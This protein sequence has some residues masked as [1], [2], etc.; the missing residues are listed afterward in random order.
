MSLFPPTKPTRVF[1]LTLRCSKGH[2]S[3]L[4]VHIVSFSI[5]SYPSRPPR[6][7]QRLN[8]AARDCSSF[9]FIVN[10]KAKF[11]V[12]H[13]RPS[14]AAQTHSQ[15]HI[16]LL[17]DLVVVPTF[18]LVKSSEVCTLYLLSFLPPFFLCRAFSILDLSGWLRNATLKCYP[19][20]P[21][22]SPQL[23]TAKGPLTVSSALFQIL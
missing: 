11:C 17:R 22:T 20:P 2:S 9:F 8:A 10:S 23:F 15:H 3:R 14:L 7:A 12:A 18:P 1:V 4:V 5:N 13:C 6:T 16:T 21:H 19:L